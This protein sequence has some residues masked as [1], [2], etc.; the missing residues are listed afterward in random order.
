MIAF[1][2]TIDEAAL[3]F[4]KSSLLLLNILIGLMML[5]MA[6]DLDVE[7]FRRLARKPKPPL[8]GLIAQF[9][10]LPALVLVFKPKFSSRK[11]LHEPAV[12]ETAS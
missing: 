8:I 4:D 5:G 1:L 10:L 9:L 6:L 11:Q 3:N 2:Q 7:D 12:A